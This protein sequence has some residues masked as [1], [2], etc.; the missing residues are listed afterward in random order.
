[1][2]TLDDSLSKA[3]S[4][5]SDNTN[6]SR[7]DKYNRILDWWRSCSKNTVDDYNSILDNFRVIFAYNSNTIEGSKIDYHTTREVF[8]GNDIFYSGSSRDLFEIQNQKVCYDI[9]I[10]S[11]LSKRV[12]DK[13]FILDIHKILLNGSYD[14]TR[15]KKGER[16][17]TFKVHDYCIGISDEG[18]YPEEVSDDIDSLLNEISTTECDVLTKA[19]YFHL[20]F[21]SIHPFADGNG[22]VGR[23]L[24]NYM[25]MQGN[26]PPVTIFDIDKTTYYLALEIWDRTGKLDG[27]KE[28]IIDE[29]IKTWKRKI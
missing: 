28:F 26:H 17:G 11:L 12:I 7:M 6:L 27:F 2:S 25:L 21:E 23:S 20:Q 8:E 19:S 9:L 29:T 1:M 10:D 18:S 15:W 14:E 13:K 4:S 3:I 22:R 5:M 16:P 24:L